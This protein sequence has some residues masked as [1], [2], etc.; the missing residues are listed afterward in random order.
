MV[1]P[2]HP[3]P[4]TAR[5]RLIFA[6]D[7]DD[8]DSAERLVR[9]LAPHV[10]MFKVGSQL[11]T[12]VG[13]LVIDLVHGLGAS[14]FLDL[15]FHDI[16]ATVGRTAKEVARARVKMFT[17]HA[18]G[19]RMMVAQ[20]NRELARITMVPGVPLPMCLAVTLLTSHGDDEL[21]EVGLAPPL[22]QHSLRLAKLAMSSGATGV[23]A[24]AQEVPTLRA[25]LPP[26]T[27]FVTPGIRSSG[28]PSDDQ[29]RVVSAKEAIEA[30]ATY[31]VVG[32]PIRDSQDPVEAAKRIV[33]EIDSAEPPC[34]IPR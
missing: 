32:R 34:P 30:G 9:R 18:L 27:V 23:V 33:D 20:A 15:K 2:L 16:P 25:A 17:V 8:V 14:V 31:I 26:D 1:P 5:D 13:P 4:K 12:S 6:L 29:A 11:F 7:V 28:A 3:P 21:R 19:G 24:S 22:T 10:G